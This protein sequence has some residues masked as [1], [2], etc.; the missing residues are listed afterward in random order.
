MQPSSFF[1]SN[2]RD[3]FVGFDSFKCKNHSL[4]DNSILN[5]GR[6]YAKPLQMYIRIKQWLKYCYNL[7]TPEHRNTDFHPPEMLIFSFHYD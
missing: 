5:Q 2:C 7:H 4:Y 6:E 1:L 3:Y